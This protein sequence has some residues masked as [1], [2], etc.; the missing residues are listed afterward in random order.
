MGWGEPRSIA[1]LSGNGQDKTNTISGEIPLVYIVFAEPARCLSA[2]I[3]T[4]PAVSQSLDES[5]VYGKG[6]QDRPEEE[7]LAGRVINAK[8]TLR[9]KKDSGNS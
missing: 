5:R 4:C 6:S 2:S 7:R 3:A 8:S 1:G 9:K